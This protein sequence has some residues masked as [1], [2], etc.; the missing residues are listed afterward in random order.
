MGSRL[1][2]RLSAQLVVIAILELQPVWAQTKPVSGRVVD[3]S[4]AAIV[5]ATVTT[6]LSTGVIHGKTMTDSQGAFELPAVP[7]GRYSLTVEK[8]HFRTAKVDME[9]AADSQTP[10]L[11]IVLQ[12]ATARESITVDGEPSYGVANASIATKLDIPLMETPMTVQVVPEQVIRD[13]G[14]TSSGVSNALAQQGVQTR[15]YAPST[16]ILIFRGFQ[17]TT[18]L[19]NGFRIEEAFAVGEGNGGVWMDNVD[20]LEVVKGP[21]S[22]LYG[23]AEPGGAVNILTKKP[24]P[25]F[26]AMVRTGA[27]SWYDRWLAVDVTG[28][29]NQNKTVIYRLNGG[30][31]TSESYLRFA[32]NYSSK[33]IAPALTWRIKPQTTLFFEGQYRSLSGANNY[34]QIPI[35]P[36]TQLPIQ[37]DLSYTFPRDTVSKFNQY[38]TMVG[39]EHHFGPNWSL[40]AKYM[41]DSVDSPLVQYIFY[42]DPTFPVQ[43]SGVLPIRRNSIVTVADTKVD[44]G[45]LDVTGRAHRWGIKHTFLFGTDFYDY[46]YDARQ[47]YNFDADPAF[48]TN[49]FN[50]G[51]YP[52][53]M[54]PLTDQFSVDRRSP[55]FYVQDQMQLPANLHLLVGGRYQRVNELITFI[56]DDK[57]IRNVFLP[58]VGLSWRP[59]TWLSA[60]YSYGENMGVNNG[61]AFP[62]K[63]LVPERSK[64]HEGGIKTQWLNERLIA[65][66][67][68]FRITKFNIAAGDPDHPGFNIG[69]GEV[70]STGVELGLQGAITKT[71]NVVLNYTYARPEVI[72]GAENASTADA[73]FIEAGQLLPYVS[74]RT[75][76]SLMNFNMPWRSLRGW[77]VGGGVNW[78]SATNPTASTTLPTGP[79]TGY[80][81][82]SAF[83]SYRFPLERF[84]ASIQLNVNNLTDERYL[85]T[86]SNNSTLVSGNYG[87]PRQVKLSLSFGF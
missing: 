83:T 68:G 20:R 7:F 9:G 61:F 78:A 2:G 16:E 18:T 58:R 65:T 63:P 41:H 51:P 80:T 69:L 6:L 4:G 79:Y 66:V 40:I 50:P 42:T 70:Q 43:P 55:A 38:R 19:W 21:S 84:D 3:S 27:G 26:H 87:T 30:L 52:W 60:Y 45:T 73:Q 35:D 1:L 54:I 37:V 71:L 14:L 29:A 53:N 36:A 59:R 31:E 76:S 62:N 46:R 5:G 22:I 72:I 67:A 39:V 81:L 33:G 17:S 25:D 85:F 28:A 34:S 77:A 15:G 13:L 8:D 32:P 86:F 44:A 10:P 75:F 12:V 11:R 49:Y 74:N 57:Y 23:R 64:Q 24:Q 47:G 56:S 82:A 48:E